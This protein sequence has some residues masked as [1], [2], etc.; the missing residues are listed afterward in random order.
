M[1]RQV[2]YRTAAECLS[3]NNTII[4]N[5]IMCGER[6]RTLCT[7]VSTCVARCLHLNMQTLLLL[8][9]ATTLAT[10]CLSNCD[11]KF[12]QKVTLSHE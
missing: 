6:E 10:K 5:M 2:K 3:S 9:L 8:A 11:S 1:K 4:H 7:T 12:I